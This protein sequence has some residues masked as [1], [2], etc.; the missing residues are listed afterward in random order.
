MRAIGEALKGVGFW[1]SVVVLVA[2]AAARRP[3]PKLAIGLMTFVLGALVLAGGVGVW[4][5]KRLVFRLRFG[6][7]W[8]VDGR[9]ARWIGGGLGLLACALV[10]FGFVAPARPERPFAGALMILAGGGLML[11]GA[12]LAHKF[13]ADGWRAS[14][15]KARARRFLDAAFR[16]WALGWL[17]LFG[18]LLV[19][20]GFLFVT[21]LR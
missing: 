1:G 18:A 16:A 4:L 9:P 10:A 21:R 5:T 14:L 17:A 11:C 20:L 19:V 13:V 3:C 6:G 7:S 2:S 12:G 8:V 15:G